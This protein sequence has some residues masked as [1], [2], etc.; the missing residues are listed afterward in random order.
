M[1]RDASPVSSKRLRRSIIMIAAAALLVWLTFFD[2]HS[3]VRRA[4]WMYERGELMEENQELLRTIEELEASLEQGLSEDEVERI[5]RE[6]YGMRRPGE[7]V[8]PEASSR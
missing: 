7:T 2:S 8:Y 4:T 1:P 6:Q 5:A 3:L